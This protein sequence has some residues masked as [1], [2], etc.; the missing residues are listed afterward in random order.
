M[1]V[2]PISTGDGSVVYDLTREQVAALGETVDALHGIDGGV[3]LILEV[4][5]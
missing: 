2:E 3:T 4:E 1:A 5:E